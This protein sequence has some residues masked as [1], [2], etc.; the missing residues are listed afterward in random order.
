M[1]FN[2]KIL[3]LSK[4]VLEVSPNVPRYV[5]TKKDD[6][7]IIKNSFLKFSDKLYCAANELHK[8]TLRKNN[9]GYFLEKLVLD[10]GENHGN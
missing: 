8:I 10:E 6:E 1:T 7:F 5:K 2:G 4:N 3:T 9:S